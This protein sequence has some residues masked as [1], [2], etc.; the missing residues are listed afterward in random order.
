[1]SFVMDPG[2][3]VWADPVNR[4]AI[5]GKGRSGPGGGDK[6]HQFSQDREGDKT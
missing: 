1:M 3:G 6:E 4:D 5:L 2:K